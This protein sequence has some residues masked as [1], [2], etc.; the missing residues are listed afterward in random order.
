MWCFY[1]DMKPGA[2][3]LNL[4]KAIRREESWLSVAMSTWGGGISS[5]RSHSSR[6]KDEGMSCLSSR[7][8]AYINRSIFLA[9]N[10][11]YNDFIIFF[12]SPQFHSNLYEWLC[13]RC[14]ACT[15]TQTELCLIYC[16]TLPFVYSLLLVLIAG[17]C[18]VGEFSFTGCFYTCKYALDMFWTHRH[19]VLVR[20]ERLCCAVIIQ[21]AFEDANN[22]NSGIW[23][24]GYSMTSVQ[25]KL[26]SRQPLKSILCVKK[27]KKRK[28]EWKSKNREW[29][30]EGKTRRVAFDPSLL[31]P[32]PTLSNCVIS[33]REQHHCLP[34]L[35]AAWRP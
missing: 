13:P 33:K 30:T 20:Y 7:K 15:P 17:C 11:C 3:K 1:C 6:P 32:P 26:Q 29:E 9:W 16:N 8:S 31:P 18:T 14:T 12:S 21:S 24:N 28:R 4:W 19:K 22:V 34:E 10:S 5:S 25:H 35:S 2:R 23:V 27:K